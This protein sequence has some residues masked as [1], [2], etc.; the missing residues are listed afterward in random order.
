LVA[1]AVS[2]CSAAST[3][4]ARSTT[5][6]RST[7]RAEA[8]RSLPND[9]TAL[10]DLFTELAVQ[11][12]LLVVV[13]Q[14]ASIGALAI[15]VA[16][17]MTVEVGYLPGH[18]GAPARRRR[19]GPRRRLISARG[20]PGGATVVGAGPPSTA[21]DAARVVVDGARLLGGT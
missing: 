1:V 14:P 18:S 19:V 7:E 15:A 17:R 12:R 2:R 5:R 10:R 21:G 8:E 4:P 3:W 11:G 13:D 6:S 9:E 16:C 20:L